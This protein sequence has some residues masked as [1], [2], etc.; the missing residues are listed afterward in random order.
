M[1]EINEN[2]WDIWYHNPDEKVEWQTA[3]PDSPE[4]ALS[5][6]DLIPGIT[7]TEALKYH[8]EGL[9]AHEILAFD[10][11]GIN[12][13]NEMI[14]WQKAEIVPE[15]AGEYKSQGI[16]Y[17]T[18]NKYKQ[19]NI[20]DPS[21][22]AKYV[23]DRHINIEN[24]KPL[25]DQNKIKMEDLITWL[26]SEIAPEEIEKWTSLGFQD[27]KEIK[28]WK[29]LGSS[30]DLASRWKKVVSS[31]EEAYRW[32]SANWKNPADV[33]ALIQQGVESP[34]DLDNSLDNLLVK[35]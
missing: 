29:Q 27:P 5:Y 30:A 2:D 31:P 34:E 33:K 32:I 6:K 19:F 12:D 22:I 25:I 14:E 7:S 11:N 8:S 16:N 3:F 23:D 18:Y 28:D 17:N 4:V 10:H 26:E 35:F 9:T 24:F 15:I 20:T 21:I 1:S 13:E